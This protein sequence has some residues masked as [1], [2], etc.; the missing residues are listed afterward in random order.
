MDELLQAA[1]D[2]EKEVIY[3]NDYVALML[4]EELIR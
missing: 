2:P 1:T 4:P 3:Y